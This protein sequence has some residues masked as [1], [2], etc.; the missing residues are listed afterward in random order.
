MRKALRWLGIGSLVFLAFMVGFTMGSSEAEEE[1]EAVAAVVSVTPT[2]EEALTE[3]TL[4][5]R[6]QANKQMTW[7]QSPDTIYAGDPRTSG[8]L[9]QGD[10]VRF[11]TPPNAEGNLRILVYPHDERTVVKSDNKVWINWSSL[12]MFRMDQDMFTCLQ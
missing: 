10:F 8:Q 7:G 4:C 6:L 2:A 1:P 3:F 11:L 12:T 9:A 5:N